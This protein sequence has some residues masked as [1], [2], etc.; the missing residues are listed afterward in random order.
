M[1]MTS[2]STTKPLE[3]PGIE[4][5]SDRMMLCKDFTRLNKRNTRKARIIRNKLKGPGSGIFDMFM[6]PMVTTTKSNTF[7]PDFQKGQNQKAYMF[8]ISSTA[9]AELKN[10]SM[11]SHV[12]VCNSP[13]GSIHFSVMLAMKLPPI[14]NATKSWTGDW[15]Y[16]QAAC[17][18]HLQK[19]CPCGGNSDSAVF[20]D[21]LLDTLATVLSVFAS[22]SKYFLLCIALTAA[23]AMVQFLR[24]L[25]MP[26]GC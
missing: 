10:T 11:P 16:A 1:D 7:Q 5:I 19:P 15:T 20:L 25:S 26:T 21:F 4:L 8:Q 14:K 18:C 24:H 17:R 9:K 3:T 13:V 23:A 22:S 12:A 6:M 2:R